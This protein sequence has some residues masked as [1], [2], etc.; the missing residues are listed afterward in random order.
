MKI[1]LAVISVL[2]LVILDFLALQ[3]I[4][5]DEPDLT[6]EYGILVISV[7]AAIGIFISLRF[8]KKE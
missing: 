2:I 1:T 8:G 3:D 7:I 5:N 6:A 4:I